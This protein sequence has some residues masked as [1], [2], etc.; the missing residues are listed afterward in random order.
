NTM[1]K[2][3]SPGLSKL[4]PNSHEEV[5]GARP[6]AHGIVSCVTPEKKEHSSFLMRQNY[7]YQLLA[8]PQTHSNGAFGRSKVHEQLY[9]Q[10]LASVQSLR[11]RVYLKDGAIQPWELDD[12]GLF[13]M[14]GDEQ[15]WHFLLIDEEDETIGCAR[16]L[17]HPSTV[18][19]ESLRISHSPLVRH[20]LWG[21]KV[22]QAVEADLKRAQE[23]SLSY[24]E[25]GGWALS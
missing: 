11:G 21:G 15:S 14:R 22:R 20:R 24:V 23:E 9:R 17:V 25:I 5:E 2:T 7:R 19:F 8:P 4:R 16:Y 13:R 1:L 18:R 10:R 6:F 12:Q 3:S